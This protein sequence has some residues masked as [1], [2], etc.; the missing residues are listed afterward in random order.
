MFFLVGEKSA[1]QSLAAYRE[2]DKLD[3]SVVDRKLTATYVY[4]VVTEQ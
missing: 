2:I 3:K 4:C 1:L